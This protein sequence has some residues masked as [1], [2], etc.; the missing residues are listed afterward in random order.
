MGPARVRSRCRQQLELLAD[1]TLDID[2]LRLE[3]IDR[4]REAIGFDLWCS[5]LVDPDTL[6]PHRPVVSDALPFGSCLPRLLVQDQSARDINSRA[7]LARSADQ[8][9]VLSAATQR[10]LARSSRW[11]DCAQPAGVGDELRAAVVDDHG[12]W[13]SF[14]LYRASDEPAFDAEDSQLMREAARILARRLRRASVS[15]TA[16]RG[17]EAGQTGVLLIDDDLQPQ[18]FTQTAREW[19]TLLKAREKAEHTPLPAHV[20]A[21]VGRLLAAEAGDD[22][23][24]PPRVRVRTSDGRW[25][26]IEAAR[27][28]GVANAIAVSVHEAS[29]ED[30]LSLSARAHGLT[31]RERE[32]VA[33]VLEG[34]DTRQL[35]ARMFISPYTVKDHLKSVF[36]KLGVHSRRELVTG[37]F[38]Q[39]A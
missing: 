36:D 2:S 4:L 29:A 32:L 22:P 1:S 24:R 3:A 14:E 8:V 33:L 30:I 6:I 9:C 13:A 7:M 23:K 12:C 21:V 16:D 27:M 38:G 5:P 34:L 35:A 28:E 31:A 37:M 10:D 15:A 39:A 20:Y 17:V 26:I 19:F 25:A 11:R 18:G